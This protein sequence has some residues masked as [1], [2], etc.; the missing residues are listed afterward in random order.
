MPPRIRSPS[1]DAE[2]GTEAE[3]VEECCLWLAPYTSFQVL[4]F[5]PG[6]MSPRGHHPQWHGPTN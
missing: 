4:C 1:P 3:A 6:T 2:A 5:P